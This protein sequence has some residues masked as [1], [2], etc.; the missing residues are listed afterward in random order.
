MYAASRLLPQAAA[1]GLQITDLGPPA[2]VDAPQTQSV[3]R[4]VK[5]CLLKA[6]LTVLSVLL[7]A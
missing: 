6:F 1:E 7:A 2:A 3:R 5:D 4:A